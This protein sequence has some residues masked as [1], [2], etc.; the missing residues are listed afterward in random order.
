[1][2]FKALSIVVFV[3]SILVSNVSQAELAWT[4]ELNVNGVM[5][6]D[7]Q[8]SGAD[9]AA[10]ITSITVDLSNT[11]TSEVA[12]DSSSITNL[13]TGTYGSFNTKV[14]DPTLIQFSNTQ[15]ANHLPTV[16]GIV[17]TAGE[18]FTFDFA[19]TTF[20]K[21]EGWGVDGMIF[22]GGTKGGGLP[23]TGDVTQADMNGGKI[24]VTFTNTASG[25]DVT[26]CTTYS[27]AGQGGSF[28][29]SGVPEPSSM[30]MFATVVGLCGIRRRRK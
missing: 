29:L 20:G 18:V 17:G 28:P 13:G 2:L 12:L 3:F 11:A 30:L 6:F 1:M 27:G 24:C 10:T 21:D 9:S 22:N 23:G 15:N 16:T 4:A 25:N 7:N 8:S 5:A 14:T 19:A 26:I